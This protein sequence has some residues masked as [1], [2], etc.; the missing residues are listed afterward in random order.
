MC[1]LNV[2]HFNVKRFLQA[3]SYFCVLNTIFILSRFVTN[4]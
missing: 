4:S 2:K 3:R 1:Q